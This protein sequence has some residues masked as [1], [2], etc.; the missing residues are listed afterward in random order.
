LILAGTIST[1]KISDAQAIPIA[2]GELDAVDSG[3]SNGG[4]EHHFVQLDALGGTGES[5]LV[6][7]NL[8]VCEGDAHGWL[9]PIS[10]IG[11]GTTTGVAVATTTALL[12][13]STRGGDMDLLDPTVLL[14]LIVGLIGISRLRGTP[15][16]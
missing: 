14:L 11:R 10:A 5:V 7:G 12:P 1:A 4:W 3:L 9:P 13:A 2:I 6:S 16:E 15:I 8:T